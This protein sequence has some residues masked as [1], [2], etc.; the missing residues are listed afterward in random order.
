MRYTRGHKAQTRRRILHEAS[1]RLRGEGISRLSIDDLMLRLG[2]THGGFYAH[3][4]SK[5]ALVA[6]ACAQEYTPQELELLAG[7]VEA[8][9][10]EESMPSLIAGYLSERHRDTPEMGCYLAALAGELAHASQ[11]ARR[12]FTA[13]FERYV[14]RI[15]HRMPGKTPRARTDAA[16]ALLTGMSGAVAVSR[17]VADEELSTHIL[18]TC[19]EFYLRAFAAGNQSSGDQERKN[20]V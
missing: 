9:T 18:D 4:A 15:A 3:F 6:E 5:D 16:L 17:A 19:R 11:A 12:T 1:R 2:L 10:Q 20:G 13:T 7:P 8:G 14:E